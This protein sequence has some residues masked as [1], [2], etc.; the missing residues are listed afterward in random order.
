MESPD[1]F[2]YSLFCDDIRQEIGGKISLIGIYSGKMFISTPLPTNLPKF[3]M[4]LSLC[5]TPQ[6]IT[7]HPGNVTLTVRFPSDPEDKPS[8]VAEIPYDQLKAIADQIE[9]PHTHAKLDA[10]L[11]T[12][13]LPITAFG[14]LIATATLPDGD[15][16]KLGSL[17]ISSGPVVQPSST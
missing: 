1:C 5:R 14:T 13:P 6:H 15:T 17:I 3:G 8:I 2:G 11:L 12:A 4:I 10:V 16:V 7:A 9:E